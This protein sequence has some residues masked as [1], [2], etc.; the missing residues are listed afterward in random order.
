MIDEI[1]IISLSRL[2]EGGAAILEAANRNHHIVI[3]GALVIRP[4]VKYIL[5]VWVISYLKLAKMNRAEDLKPWAIIIIKAPYIPQEVLVS[6]PAS[7]NPMWP[8]EE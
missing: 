7:I 8:T 1:S 2:I 5:R 4:L 3:I 6:R